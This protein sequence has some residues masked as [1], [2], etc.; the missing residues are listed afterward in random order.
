[1]DS[2]VAFNLGPL[3]VFSMG[4]RIPGAMHRLREKARRLARC[5]KLVGHAIGTFGSWRAG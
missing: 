1:M 2:L 3:A 5:R 4:G